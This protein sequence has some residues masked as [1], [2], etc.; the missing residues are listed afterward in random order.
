MNAYCILMTCM[1]TLLTFVNIYSYN[2]RRLMIQVFNDWYTKYTIQT[3]ASSSIAY[4]TIFAWTSEPVVF[5]NASPSIL[6]RKTL[7][8]VNIDWK[9]S[10]YSHGGI[11]FTANL[12]HNVMLYT[13]TCISSETRHTRTLVVFFSDQAS[14]PVSTNSTGTRL[15]KLWKKTQH[16]M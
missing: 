3:I 15:F 5:I 14:S 16:A 1:C 12:N 11:L 13:F 7:T 9:R 4:V 6:T 2:N 10:K 8:L